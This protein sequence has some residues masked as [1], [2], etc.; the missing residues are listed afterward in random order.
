MFIPRI[1]NI[2]TC[3]KCKKKLIDQNFHRCGI[4]LKQ[5]RQGKITAF[6]D[7]KCPDCKHV[8]QYIV[9]SK[10]SDDLPGDMFIQ[11]GRLLNKD[12]IKQGSMTTPNGMDEFL[13]GL[14]NDK[15]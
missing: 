5:T 11:F 2:H 4:D 3:N 14:S 9:P 1:L 13:K 10:D 8:G 6:F 12:F 7:Y 15:S